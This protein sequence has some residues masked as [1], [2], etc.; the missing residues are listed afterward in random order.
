MSEYKQIIFFDGVCNLCNSF[1]DFV[2][3]H[4]KE[5]IFQVASL[6]GE[7]AKTKLPAELRDSVSSVV[8]YSQGELL[9]KSDAALSVLTQLGGAWS[10]LKVFW[11][12]PRSLRDIMYDLVARYRYVLFGRK[13]SCR[14]PTKEERAVFL[15]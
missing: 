15:D 10:L 12:V 14:L 13:E 1:V 8:L 5:R 3:R 6:Q 4:D 7:T 2:L 9:V 11:V